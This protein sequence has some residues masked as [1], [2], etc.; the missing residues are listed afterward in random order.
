MATTKRVIDASPEKVFAVL[1]D[2]W[3]YATWVVG[4][5]R[6]REVD[7]GWP[8]TG[9]RIHHSVGSWPALI[10][11]STRVLAHEQD[12][13]LVLRA[14]G[15]P[16]G[17]AEIEILL[18]PHPDGTEVTINEEAVAGPGKL[19]PEPLKGITIKWRNVEALRRLAYIAERRRA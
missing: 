9:T 17:E 12:R 14:R 7:D 8:Q 10:N 1:S 4:A 19:V 3:L 6:I 13:R 5:S 2:G 18:T 16:I 15:W 11:D